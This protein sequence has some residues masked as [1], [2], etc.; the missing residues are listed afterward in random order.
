[1]RMTYRGRLIA[2]AA[3]VAAPLLFGS[4]LIVQSQPAPAVPPLPPAPAPIMP[5]Q[6]VPAHTV[7]LMTAEGMTV[8]TAEVGEYV[9]AAGGIGCITGILHRG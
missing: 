3:L 4:I 8:H 5:P 1:M 6:L 7:D 2:C 9:K